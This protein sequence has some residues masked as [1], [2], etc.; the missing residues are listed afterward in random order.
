M[1]LNATKVPL[2]GIATIFIA[3]RVPMPAE[4]R[5]P[6]FE[7]RSHAD[8]AS[9]I[10]VLSG[11]L[12]ML[13]APDLEH[14]VRGLCDEDAAELVLDLRN[15]TFM[16]S[17]GLR[18]T[19]A[20]YELCQESGYSFAVIPGPRQVHALFELTGLAERLPFRTSLQPL[21]PPQDGLLPRLF[22]PAEHPQ[23]DIP[24]L[25]GNSGTGP[26]PPV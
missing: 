7:I 15:L 6:C 4:S 1:R 9:R 10:L 22:A 25:V 14:A 18:S 2:E 3:K 13:V 24:G 26:R 5:P 11:E 21:T 19:L 8:G 12:D 17:T 23:D 20:A 16:D